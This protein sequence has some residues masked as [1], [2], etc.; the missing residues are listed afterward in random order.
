[1][2]FERGEPLAPEEVARRVRVRRATVAPAE[3]REFTVRNRVVVHPEVWEAIVVTI[4]PPLA[5]AWMAAGAWTRAFYVSYASSGAIEVRACGLLM[6]TDPCL[7]L[8]EVVLRREER[9]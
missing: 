8:D 6:D 2:R 3:E 7:R 4:A 5:D 1:M 9:L